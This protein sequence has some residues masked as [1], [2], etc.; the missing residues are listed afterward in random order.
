M[1]MRS[2]FQLLR[3]GWFEK[4]DSKSKK[5]D[6]EQVYTDNFVEVV[7]GRRLTTVSDYSNEFFL[8]YY[9]K[10]EEVREVFKDKTHAS[11]SLNSTLIEKS[12]FFHVLECLN[13]PKGIFSL[14]VAYFQIALV[15]L[16]SILGVIL[17][18]LFLPFLFL[19]NVKEN[20]FS[21][22]F[23]VENLFLVRSRSGYSKLRS[24]VEEAG[25][26]AVIFDNFSDL[27]GYECSVYAP[28]KT[29]LFFRVLLRT[30]MFSIRDIILI[31]KDAK[32][33][34]GFLFSLVVFSHY[35]K[36]IPH[37]ALYEACLM[38]VLEVAGKGCVVYSA[39]KEDRFALM[40]TR[41]CADKS[42][43]LICIPHG[44]EY[45]LRLPGGLCGNVFYCYSESSRKLLSEIYN[46]DKFLFSEDVLTK[47]LGISNSDT[48]GVIAQI[49]FFT[50]PRE[51]AVNF[52]I[53]DGLISLGARFHIKLHPLEDE[54]VY[55]SKFSDLSIIPSLEDA[56][57]S[58]VCIARK[59]TVLIE[60]SHRGRLAVAILENTKDRVFA[61]RLFPS[62]TSERIRKVSDF[63]DL[64]ALLST[65]NK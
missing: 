37:K 30:V 63:S 53:I 3:T 7:S 65:Q 14:L 23:N 62:L 43:E 6:L 34:I 27:K 39:E 44:L 54:A 49:C 59:S 48:N 21:R 24:F 28:L 5:V 20:S 8:Y 45:G 9:L 22:C 52:R 41:C 2:G 38:E 46:S 1:F 61:T 17:L 51:Q 64:N 26:S 58:S 16:I 42:R 60:A 12:I 18:S 31:I 40:Q 33:M 56:L 47:M 10:C 4:G 25:D 15:F 55:R 13:I 36:R 50:E 57:R 19:R 32:S 11:C 35:W 29:R